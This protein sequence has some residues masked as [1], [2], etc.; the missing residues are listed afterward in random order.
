MMHRYYRAPLKITELFVRDMMYK[1]KNILGTRGEATF[2]WV[3][4]TL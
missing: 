2:T 3:I 1:L 4:L